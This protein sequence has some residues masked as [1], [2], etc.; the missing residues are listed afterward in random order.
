MTS[1]Y[2]R[3]KMAYDA[4]FLTGSDVRPVDPIGIGFHHN[5]Q[6][7]AD[8]NNDHVIIHLDDVKLSN[9]M[10]SFEQAADI[11]LQLDRSVRRGEKLS[12]TSYRLL[13]TSLKRITKKTQVALDPLPAMESLDSHTKRELTIVMENVVTDTIKNIW[14][15][16][17]A[18]FIGM[19]NKIK[20]WFIKAFDGA[21]RLK[22]QAEA[23]K[24]KAEANSTSSPKNTNFEMAGVKFL[25]IKG[26]IATP[27]EIVKGV[28]D[29][30][31]T[32]S[33][34]LDKNADEYNNM[35][36]KIENILKITIEQARNMKDSDASGKEGEE[37]SKN[38]GDS[39]SGFQG[40]TAG[41]GLLH[42]S[43]STSISNGEENKLISEM[44]GR[45]FDAAEAA[46]IQTNSSNEI[47]GDTRWDNDKVWA[48]RSPVDYLGSI[49]LVF[50]SA[51]QAV[52]NV[53]SYSAVKTGYKIS[54]EPLLAQPK[55]IDDNGTFTTASAEQVIAICEPVI[56][57]CDLLMK[58]KL[59]FE[60]RDK[61]TGNLMKQMEQFVSSNSSLKG[62]GQ[63]HVQNTISTTVAL[64]KKLQDG[65]TRWA[66]YAFSVLNKAVVYGRNSLA[67]Y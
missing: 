23:L 11:S 19:H 32:T 40:T 62:P 55:E 66:K 5:D 10:E 14:E 20:T 22:K 58:Y 21:G 13:N 41:Q 52:S 26:K 30:S 17:K 8:L 39:F 53:E 36:P 7:I 12:D 42:Q 18:A 15:K 4:S 9:A 25:N 44:M 2:W 31:N 24:A 65:E 3:I 57:A 47:K 61:N 16:I 37:K 43:G 60:A 49:M 64:V 67:Q 59:L 45:F 56:A 46:G 34:L 51:T 48:Y 50:T 35:F 6:E 38:I 1:I 63:R 27:A 54:P 33:V 28:Q 29:I